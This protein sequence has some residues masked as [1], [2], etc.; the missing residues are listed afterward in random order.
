MLPS[1]GNRDIAAMTLASCHEVESIV[2]QKRVSPLVLQGD[3][4]LADRYLLNLGQGSRKAEELANAY[5]VNAT[6]EG[7]LY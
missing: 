3:P 7:S 5:R 2:P 6:E 4:L 1:R